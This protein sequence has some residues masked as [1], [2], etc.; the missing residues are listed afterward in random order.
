[1][2]AI[3][4]LAMGEQQLGFDPRAARQNLQATNENDD[5]RPH[6]RLTQLRR[7]DAWQKPAAVASTAPIVVTPPYM[8]SRLNKERI[9]RH[10]AATKLVLDAEPCS[11]PLLSLATLVLCFFKISN[12]ADVI[13]P[14]TS[15]ALL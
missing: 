11:I 5:T 3:K 2:A 7:N 1:M 6:V 8:E 9:R 13:T 12:G 10:H 4:S 15:G 14:E